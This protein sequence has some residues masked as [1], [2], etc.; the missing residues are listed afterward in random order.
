MWWHTLESMHIAHNA[1]ENDYNKMERFNICHTRFCNFRV[2]IISSSSINPLSPYRNKLK[3]WFIHWTRFV[4]GVHRHQAIV[5]C[6]RVTELFQ[7]DTEPT[8]FVTIT[9]QSAV[10]RVVSRECFLRRTRTLACSV[11][12]PISLVRT[13]LAPR[14]NQIVCLG[15]R[16]EHALLDK[17]PCVWILLFVSDFH[18]T[19]GKINEEGYKDGSKHESKKQGVITQ[20][21]HTTLHDTIPIYLSYW[22]IKWN[23]DMDGD[24]FM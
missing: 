12:R 3:C 24:D 7:S 14:N 9:Q 22:F 1:Q 23:K 11:V 5:F 15:R 16:P 19:S 8:P 17:S 2:I 21:R 10:Q 4:G 6:C 20:L 13:E 18:E